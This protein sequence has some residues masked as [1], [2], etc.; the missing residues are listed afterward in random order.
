MPL[1]I[2]WRGHKNSNYL[3]LVRN[4]DSENYIVHTKEENKKEESDI[5]GN[6]NPSRI[7]V[8]PGDGPIVNTARNRAYLV[9]VHE[10]LTIDKGNFQKISQL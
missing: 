9:S 8:I 1:A 7:L 6:H 4:K 10:W 2:L 5:L 3:N